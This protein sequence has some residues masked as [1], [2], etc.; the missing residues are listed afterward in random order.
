MSWDYLKSQTFFETYEE[1]AEACARKHGLRWEIVVKLA[2]IGKHDFYDFLH[3]HKAV[4]LADYVWFVESY[5]HE[6]GSPKT[7][8]DRT[9]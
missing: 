2:L 8:W 5:Y 3:S 1:Q 9:K 6:D 4:D 7:G